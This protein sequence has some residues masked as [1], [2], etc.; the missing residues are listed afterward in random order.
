MSC[1]ACCPPQRPPHD[2]LRLKLLWARST[3]V[4]DTTTIALGKSHPGRQYNDGSP[5]QRPP[6]SPIQRIIG[7]PKPPHD[8]LQRAFVRT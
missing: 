4:A 6:R 8:A 3:P 1:S 5:E 2:A 7:Y